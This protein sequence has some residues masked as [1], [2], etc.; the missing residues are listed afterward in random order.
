M[1]EEK[2]RVEE[3]FAPTHEVSGS[4]FLMLGIGIKNI[5]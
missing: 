1:A 2:A 4:S 3:G 5:Q